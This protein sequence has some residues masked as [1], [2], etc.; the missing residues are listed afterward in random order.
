M[1]R[2]SENLSS[3]Q[4]QFE[5]AVEIDPEFALAWV[6]IADTHFLQFEYGD[7]RLLH[8]AARKEAVARA[9][10]I[11]DQLGE[12]Y[13][14]LATI[15]DN[16]QQPDEMNAAFQKAYELSP[17][18]AQAY[19]WNAESTHGL[20]NLEKKLS[21][22]Y[23][24]V[25]LDPMSSVIQ[26]SI[27]ETLYLLGRFDE[28]MSQLL[29]LLEIDAGFSAAHITIARLHRDSGRMAEAV[30]WYREA[31]VHDPGNANALLLLAYILI[32]LEDM[33]GF[34]A[35]R[36]L[37]S[38][39]LGPDNLM[40]TGAGYWLKLDQSDWDGALALLKSLPPP[41]QEYPLVISLI[42][43]AH[44]F[45]GEFQ[46]ALDYALIAKPGWSDPNAW[47]A[48]IES[49]SGAGR[50]SGAACQVAGMFLGAGN[51][52]LGN[53]LLMQAIDFLENEFPRLV[54]NA[55]S[56]P[57][58]GICYLL[59][60]DPDRALTHFERRVDLGAFHDW[61]RWS[62]LPFWEPLRKHPRY[63]AMVDRIESKLEEQR[64]LIELEVSSDN[65]D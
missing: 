57:D 65:V 19:H 41:V 37:M 15:L 14:S 61:W 6:G 27:G 30:K 63:L 13:T 52:E 58:L 20:A 12:A 54:Q 25:R 60:D 28:A 32:S 18:Y 51:P 4:E 3:A 33:E 43:D 64:K 1:A 53:A 29:H 49:N 34:S 45:D 23:Q 55:D 10:A 56:Q 47:P 50:N 42:S 38:E 35:T 8:L 40:T 24:A 16:E 9:L 46:E 59:T 11:D 44:L 7:R 5:L 17:N 62:E 22:L 2:H 39:Q 31:L 21:L 26:V 36:D 48:L